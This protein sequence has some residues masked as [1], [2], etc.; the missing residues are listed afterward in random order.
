MG[1]EYV[2]RT[3]NGFARRQLGFEQKLTLSTRESDEA[4]NAYFKEV[5]RTFPADFLLRVFA[6]PVQISGALGWEVSANYLPRLQVAREQGSPLL[7]IW[8]A[9][10]SV[11]RPLGMISSGI[12]IMVVF[13]AGWHSFRL[14]LAALWIFTFL[15]T[16]PV[17]EFQSRHY[18]HLEILPIFALGGCAEFLLH[19]VRW[20]RW[21]G[22]RDLFRLLWLWWVLLPVL[23]LGGGAL[24][25]LR[26]YQDAALR[27]FVEEVLAQRRTSL[28]WAKTKPEE[29]GVTALA[30]RDFP[31][32]P[33]GVHQT[34]YAVLSFNFAQCPRENFILQA[35]LEDGPVRSHKARLFPAATA[36]P[37]TQHVLLP[38]HSYSQRN[39]RKIYLPTPYVRCLMGIELVDLLPKWSVLPYFNL[40]EG[41]REQEFFRRFG[42]MPPDSSPFPL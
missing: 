34:H 29:S 15:A 9:R 36:A 41:W 8:H 21:K 30:V 35:E 4:G 19:K 17:L 13:L 5:I 12:C 37:G 26:H 24:F 6:A 20:R 18:T 10:A 27:N 28:S 2:F 32:V 31:R 33:D 11:V 42:S 23:V 14:G 40:S 22:R 16:Y 38:V 25:Y 7:D 1:D 3:V 39:P